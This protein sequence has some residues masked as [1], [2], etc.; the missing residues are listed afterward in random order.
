MKSIFFKLL[1]AISILAISVMLVS[2]ERDKEKKEAAPFNMTELEVAVNIPPI[3]L[4]D[5]N[6][7]VFERWG[8]ARNWTFVFFGYTNCPDVCPVALVD[9][10]DVYHKLVEEEDLFNTKFLFITVD[11]G[12]DSVETLKEYIP[13]F[14]KK[15]VGVTGAPEEIAKL[16]D[17]LGISYIR[18]PGSESEEDY[19]VDHSASILL[20]DPLMRLRAIFPPPHDAVF[21]ASEFRDLRIKYKEECCLTDEKGGAVIFDF[22]KKE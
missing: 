10:N 4:I 11:P 9:M 1:I 17:K 5:H 18:V 7:R 16:T 20:I 8:F 14:N 13:F 2:C 3:S 12:R 19:Y 21:M 15:F 6:G 22:R